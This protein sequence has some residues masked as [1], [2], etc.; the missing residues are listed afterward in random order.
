[1]NNLSTKDDDINGEK[2]KHNHIS[3]SCIIT[4]EEADLKDDLKPTKKVCFTNCYYINFN[5]HM[6]SGP[7]SWFTLN[8]K[9]DCKTVE[10]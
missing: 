5:T 1:M 7:K 8:S 9:F 3:H 2:D 4:V 6:D 10:Q